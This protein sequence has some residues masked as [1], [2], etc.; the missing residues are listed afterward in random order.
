[1][2]MQLDRFDHPIAPNPIPNDSQQLLELMKESLDYAGSGLVGSPAHAHGTH[3]YYQFKAHF[4][5]LISQE[6]AEA[7]KGLTSAT[8]GLK[9]ATWLLAA[10]TV[11]LGL[12]EGFKMW[13]GH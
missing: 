3:L 4:D 5:L 12:V 9:I 2:P 6:T 8:R 13:R 7:H 10:I 1:M 11:L